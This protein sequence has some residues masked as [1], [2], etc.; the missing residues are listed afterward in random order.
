MLRRSSPA[1]GARRRRDR[2]QHPSLRHAHRRWRRRAPRPRCRR[3]RRGPPTRR[4]RVRHDRGRHQPRTLLGVDEDRTPGAR[5]R[6]ADRGDHRHRHGVGQRLGAA[7]WQAAAAPAARRCRRGVE[8]GARQR[9]TDPVGAA[10][11]R[12]R[13]RRRQAAQAARPEGDRLV[14]RGHRPRRAAAGGLRDLGRRRRR[15]SVD[16]PRPHRRRTGAAQWRVGTARRRVDERDDPR[17]A[18][19]PGRVT[20]GADRPARRWQ[21]VRLPERRAALLRDASARPAPRVVRDRGARRA[22]GADH[23]RWRTNVGVVHV[24]AGDGRRRCRAARSPAVPDLRPA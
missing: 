15:A 20:G 3:L 6:G 5:R 17:R 18:D 1:A 23:G 2:R 4:H 22:G 7:H 8:R 9:R 19:G 11:D 14:S 13:A 21:S 24:V 12:Q 10:P 16:D